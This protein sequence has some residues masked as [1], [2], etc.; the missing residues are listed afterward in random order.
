MSVTTIHLAALEFPSIIGAHFLTRMGFL[1]GVAAEYDQDC[2]IT[3]LALA[4]DYHVLVINLGA[5]DGRRV[6]VE[7]SGLAILQAALCMSHS[8][9]VGFDMD[10]V[11]TSLFL[12]HGLRIA[13][14]I[15]LES[16]PRSCVAPYPRGSLASIMDVLGGEQAVNTDAVVRLFSQSGPIST[17]VDVALRAWVALYTSKCTVECA[18]S[19]SQ[20][21]C[22]NTVLM[23]DQVRRPKH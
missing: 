13:A 23:T 18:S 17:P 21:P 5:S 15:D 14:A 1:V 2:K 4:D 12:D 19:L 6:P 11:A 8:I 7:G 20:T 10:G 3:T 22:I 16:V 9:H